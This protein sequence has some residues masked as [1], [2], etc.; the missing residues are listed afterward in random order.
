MET[1][2]KTL[3]LDKGTVIG[4]F[5]VIKKVGKG[6]YGVIFQV[7]QISSQNIYAM[8]CEL[9]SAKKTALDNEIQF[10]RKINEKTN[11]PCF[12]KYIS[13]GETETIKYM[14]IEYLG[15]SLS[16]LLK[17]SEERRFSMSTFV[18]TSIEML[19]CIRCLHENGFI[20]RDIKP[21]NFLVRGGHTDF[22]VLIDFGLVK[23]YIDPETNEQLPQA[24]KS[25]FKGTL[26]YCSLYVHRKIDQC[27][28]DDLISWFYS[29]F[30]LYSGEIFWEESK[31]K[32]FVLR[33]KQ[34]FAENSKIYLPKQMSKIYTM[35]MELGHYDTPEYDKYIDLL[36]S[37]GKSN[38]VRLDE[39]L[40]WE[41]YS[42]K[43][44]KDK[45]EIPSNKSDS[46]K[47][48][49][50]PNS[51]NL[52]IGQTKELSQESLVCLLI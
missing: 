10:I 18:N 31:D 36:M 47:A 48:N 39:P 27:R 43:F 29:I 19:K 13:S 44:A 38:N 52:I 30:E 51:S 8:K 22:C 32:K 28:R 12:P 37:L 23:S 41:K 40:D 50:K 14:V 34:S 35:L 24:N 21:S 16:R 1:E 20:H 2:Q 3:F 17:C 11:S 46:D 6:G 33:A 26:K 5:E 25:G 7:K 4:G 9:L 49:S 15:P 45:L 42:D